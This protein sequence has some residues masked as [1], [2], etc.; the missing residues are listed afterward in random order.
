MVAPARAILNPHMRQRWSPSCYFILSKH[1]PKPNAKPNP[2]P[3]AKPNPKPNPKPT[4]L[5]TMG[6]WCPSCS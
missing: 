2:K 3:N 5:L 1:N 4:L 6:R